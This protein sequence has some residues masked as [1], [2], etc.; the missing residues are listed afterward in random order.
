MQG[1][2][3]RLEN[4]GTAC[5][6]RAMTGR[7]CPLHLPRRVSC[8]VLSERPVAGHREDVGRGPT[9]DIITRRRG[10]GPATRAGRGSFPAAEG[11]D[12]R[13]VVRRQAAAVRTPGLH[14]AHGWD[15]ARHDPNLGR[16]VSDEAPGEFVGAH[17]P[18]PAGGDTRREAIGPRLPATFVEIRLV[19]AFARNPIQPEGCGIPSVANIPGIPDAL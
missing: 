8:R 15:P 12:A 17:A 6:S 14:G 11:V 9:I 7:P 1:P 18:R 13:R 10:H 3:R 4:A 2:R 16:L 19:P 5:R